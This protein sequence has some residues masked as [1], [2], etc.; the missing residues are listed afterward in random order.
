MASQCYFLICRWGEPLTLFIGDLEQNPKFAVKCNAGKLRWNSFEL[1][2][3]S[4]FC[5]S[6][7]SFLAGIQQEKLANNEPKCVAKMT[8]VIYL[9]D[10]HHALHP[11]GASQNMWMGWN[12]L[13]A[14][15][16]IAVGFFADEASCSRRWNI[17]RIKEPSQHCIDRSSAP[18]KVCFILERRKRHQKC[19]TSQAI[20]DI[21]EGLRLSLS[22]KGGWYYLYLPWQPEEG[23]PS[24]ANVKKMVEC[25][26]EIPTA[27]LPAD[28]NQTANSL[29][30][31]GAHC[32]FRILVKKGLWRTSGDIR[33]GE[34]VF[35]QTVIIILR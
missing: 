35:D 24:S 8:A 19:N 11:C 18:I 26:S 27:I 30:P 33:K 7:T 17:F 3:T 14:R 32:K 10:A 1:M 13:I 28:H 2:C 16:L 23:S 12:H 22:K 25:N 31:T 5:S 21:R 4:Q 15:Y 9:C 34:M 20:F 6:Y 29:L